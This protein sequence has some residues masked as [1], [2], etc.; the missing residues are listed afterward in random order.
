MA[1]SKRALNIALSGDLFLDKEKTGISYMAENV[2]KAMIENNPQ[3]QFF[4]NIFDD[5][6]D[7]FK[8]TSLSGYKNVTIRQS[9]K[10]KYWRYKLISTFLPLP[11]KLFFHDNVDVTQFFNYI[12]YPGVKGKK[13]TIVH[14]MAYKYLPET[15]TLRTRF[16]L[17]MNMGRT[18]KRADIILAVSQFTKDEMLR[19]F[20]IDPNKIKVI[21]CVIN[22]D[23]FNPNYNSEQ[24]E[25]AKEKYGIKEPYFLYLGTLEPRKNIVKQIEAYALL[26]QKMVNAPKFVLAGKKGWMYD[27]IFEKVKQLKLE[28]DIIFTGYIDNDDAPLL[29]K[30][31]VAF[32]YVS[33]YEGFGMPPLE[34]MS[35][36]VPVIV[37]NTSSLPEVVGEAG[38]KADPASA[39]EIAKAME[40]VATDEEYR[41]ELSQKSLAR[42]EHFSVQKTAKEF[43][44]IFEELI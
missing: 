37:S 32:I 19:S 6:S 17:K 3:S 31:S 27:E 25:N 9:G 23:L 13:V 14:D 41:K 33:L 10:I 2:S 28:E 44:E 5:R 18:I 20:K 7:A 36:G 30:G 11:Y 12:I 40:K 35:C 43:Y 22:K 26:K 24:I 38:I 39:E 1:E 21:P 34:A 8:S 16:F 15:V 29:M 4:I 42:A